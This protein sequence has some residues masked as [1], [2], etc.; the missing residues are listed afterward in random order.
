MARKSPYNL[1][2]KRLFVEYVTQYN[3][4][5]I[6]SQYVKDKIDRK[7]KEQVSGYDSEMNKRIAHF[8]DSKHEFWKKNPQYEITPST[9][10]PVGYPNVTSFK[11]Q[12]AKAQDSQAS[13]S[14][15]NKPKPAPKTESFADKKLRLSRELLLLQY[16]EALQKAQ[17]DLTKVQDILKSNPELSTQEEL[18]SA[19]NPITETE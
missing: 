5:Q 14:K 1:A 19:L 11:K 10:L 16:E 15:S 2:F 3:A 4:A 13:P 7:K 12:V 8:W 17:E 9:P 6:T 18:D